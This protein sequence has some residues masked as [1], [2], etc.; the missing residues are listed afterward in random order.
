V[1]MLVNATIAQREWNG[2]RWFNRWGEGYAH[3]LRVCL[4][5]A[6]FWV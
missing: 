3:N 6:F 1:A 4:R 5:N 2:M